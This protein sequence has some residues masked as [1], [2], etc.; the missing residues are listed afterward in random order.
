MDQED[1]Q[2]EK[3]NGIKLLCCNYPEYLIVNKDDLITRVP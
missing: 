1:I 3:P 2:T